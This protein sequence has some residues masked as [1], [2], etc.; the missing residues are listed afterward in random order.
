MACDGFVLLA[1]TLAHETHE[2]VPVDACNIDASIHRCSIHGPFRLYRIHYINLR[3][4][5]TLKRPGTTPSSPGG[6]ARWRV[7]CGAPLLWQPWPEGR[8]KGESFFLLESRPVVF[9]VHASMR[10]WEV[11]TCENL[12]PSSTVAKAN[13]GHLIRSTGS[14]PAMTYRHT[15]GQ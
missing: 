4:S 2:G 5:C 14:Y 12:K 9:R 6:V 7:P 11:K 8:S 13:D 10:I 3:L 1:W 15:T